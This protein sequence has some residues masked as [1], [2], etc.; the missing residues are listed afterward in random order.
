MLGKRFASKFNHFFRLLKLTISQI[1]DAEIRFDRFWLRGHCLKGDGRCDFLHTIPP[2]RLTSMIA[3]SLDA[4]SLISLFRSI[5]GH[6][7]RL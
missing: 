7:S 2:V 4:E 3:V 6:A 1:S 5:L